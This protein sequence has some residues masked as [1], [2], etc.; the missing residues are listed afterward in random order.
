[1]ISNPFPSSSRWRRLS[2]SSAGRWSRIGFTLIELLVV[3]AIIAI[4]AAMLLPALAAAKQ[5]AISIKCVNNLKQVSLAG[6]MYAN[7]CPKFIPYLDKLNDIWIGELTEYQSGVNEVRFCPAAANT[8]LVKGEWNAKDM[9]SAWRWDSAVTPGKV[10]WGSYGLNGYLYSDFPNT[11]AV[12]ASQFNRFSTIQ[13]PTKTPFI[14]DA[15]WADFWPGNIQGP[16]KNM[17]TGDANY[18]MGRITIGRHMSGGVPSALTSTA[19]MPGSLNMA[20][21]DGHVEGLRMTKLWELNWSATYKAP[22][23]LPPPQ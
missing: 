23:S 15:I 3:I 5:R 4:L 2:A 20:F 22:N 1:M 11:G 8:N 13:N 17:T 21:V 14:A 7:D 9:K 12:N 18:G 6:L 10:W 19:A 16:A